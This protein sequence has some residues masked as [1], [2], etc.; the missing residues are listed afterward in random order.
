MLQKWLQGLSLALYAPDGGASGGS[1]D[2]GEGN[3]GDSG[4]GG[5]ADG[6]SSGDASSYPDFH[7]Q[8]PE[9]LR[10]HEALKGTDGVWST[11]GEIVADAVTYR[12]SRERL[13]EI[14][15]EDATPEQREDFAK[16]L[17]RP[18]SPGDYSL[19]KPDDWPNTVPWS[20]DGAKA[21][22][23]SMF[24][25]GIPKEQAERLFRDNMGSVR[26]KF[27]S[28]QTVDARVQEDWTRALEAT[29]KDGLPAALTKADRAMTLLGDPTVA[30]ILK[31]KGIDRHPGI[32]KL[33]TKSWD[34]IGE[35]KI[36]SGSIDAAD[37]S[38]NTTTKRAE[39]RYSNTKFPPQ[40]G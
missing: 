36:F 29:Y 22:A 39:S 17:G 9:N 15:G 14:P 34:G 13:V 7:K 19:S 18:D 33:L 1:G 26:T 8:Y 10:G 27:L 40:R 24:K 16:S 38:G 20:N 37:P 30:A 6:S 3:G 4:S 12:E 23:E 25:S 32:V 5:G 28:Q 35:D 31:D 11:V 2:G 21:F